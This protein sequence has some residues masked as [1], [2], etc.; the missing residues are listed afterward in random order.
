MFAALGMPLPGT[1]AIYGNRPI[2][3]KEN[4]KLLFQGKKPYWMPRAGWAYCDMNNFRPRVH[5]DNVVTHLI[6]DD[7]GAYP[8]ESNV[9]HSDWYDLDW[10]YVPVAGGATVQPGNPKIE[11]MNDWRA[12]IKLPVLDAM[13]IEGCAAKDKAFLET[14]QYNEFGI[15]SGFWERLISLMDVSGAAIALIDELYRVS[16]EAWQNEEE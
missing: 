7:Q 9:M 1:E 11:D 5:P 13:D 3:E 12:I 16:R 15:L 14:P 10:V 4:F 2:T 6:F 8:Y